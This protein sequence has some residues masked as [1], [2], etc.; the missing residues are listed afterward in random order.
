MSDDPEKGVT[1]PCGEVHGYPGLFVMDGAA[2]P[3][4]IGVNPAA[5]ITAVAERNMAQ[6][7]RDPAHMQAAADWWAKQ[8]WTKRDHVALEPPLGGGGVE[9]V[10]RPIGIAFEE[11]MSGFHWADPVPGPDSAYR[12]AEVEGRLH[13]STLCIKLG[14]T[15][16]DVATFVHSERQDV[17]IEGEA[18]LVWDAAGIADETTYKVSGTLTLP[19]SGPGAAGRMSYELRFDGLDGADADIVL[20][21]VKR[22]RNDPGTDSWRDTSRL[23]TTLIGPGGV[24]SHGVIHVALDEFLFDQLPSFRVLHTDDPARI[25]WALSSFGA[26]FFGQLQRIYLPQLE[27]AVEGFLHLDLR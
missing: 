6:L 18:K 19:G 5:T 17:D 26:Y 11:T 12:A 3:R 24:R 20:A 22:I 15:V 4:S 16:E 7:L 8:A 1:N 21:G 27:K 9:T 25:A 10:N 2:F 14:A 13:G 23:L